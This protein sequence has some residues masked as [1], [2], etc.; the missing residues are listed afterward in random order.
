MMTHQ[1]ENHDSPAWRIAL[2]LLVN[3]SGLD[4]LSH[5]FIYKPIISYF[6]L[7]IYFDMTYDIGDKKH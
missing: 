5:W 6:I 2:F 3:P 4:L 7:I 1:N